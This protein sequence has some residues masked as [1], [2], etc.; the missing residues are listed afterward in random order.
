MRY[1]SFMADYTGSCLKDDYDSEIDLGYF[2]LPKEVLN[3]IHI[4]NK[5]YSQVIPLSEGERLSCN[6]EIDALDA[7]GI[8]ICNELKEIIS[9]DV[10]LRYFSEGKFKY[11]A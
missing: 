10:K 9:E 3:K 8:S 6:K 1:L 11:L 7:E 4:W 2:G 5:K